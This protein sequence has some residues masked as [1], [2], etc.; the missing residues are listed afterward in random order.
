MSLALANNHPDKSM[1]MVFKEGI[2]PDTI[3]I[4]LN[5]ADKS[6]HST[7]MQ[8][9]NTGTQETGE[10]RI[11]IGYQYSNLFN[12]DHISSI[13]YSTSL[14][15]PDQVSQWVLSYSVP[16][17][18]LADQLSVYYSDSAIETST[19]FEDTGNNFDINGAG[20]VFGVRYL[21]TLSKIKGYK[22]SFTF[23]YDDKTFDNQILLGSI[24]VSGTNKVDSKPLSMQYE[25]VKT[26]SSNPYSVS[27]SYVVNTT[28]DAAAY[29]LEARM[30]D[31][32]WS[33]F[34]YAGLYDWS[35]TTALVR[36]KLEGQE[37]TQALISG[38]QFGVGGAN[39]VRGYGERAILGD[40]GY[41]VSI[42]YWNE[43]APQP[44]T[45]LVFYDKASVGYV[46]D[47][48]TGI[49]RQAP[50]SVG[51]GVRWNMNK[52][53]RTSADLAFVLKDAGEVE[54]GDTKLH[55]NLVYLF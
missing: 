18:D 31:T 35:L 36:F 12:K 40:K 46:E 48:G 53:L 21:Y 25:L 32:S 29:E 11:G 7:F 3:D 24:I 1:Q 22:Q 15:K 2:V 14:E 17:Y 42:E 34:R 6:P 19:P 5:V 10:S 37:A 28:G 33:L 23:G 51:A 39:S 27:I 4:A 26:A 9:S 55:F 45:W 30:P 44:W 52:H 49:L 8:L 20:T 47:I 13:N 41:S 16:F 54:S 38:E 43:R 50:E